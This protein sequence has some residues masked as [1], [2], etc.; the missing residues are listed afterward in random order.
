MS[1]SIDDIGD[2]MA[3]HERI[4]AFWNTHTPFDAAVSEPT[5]ET[6]S[7]TTDSEDDDTTPLAEGETVRVAHP[8]G[9][10]EVTRRDGEY[11]ARA[12]EEEWPLSEAAVAHHLETY[13]W[14][15]VDA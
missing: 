6:M 11:H 15:V 4:Q 12:G 1:D 7:Q 2:E 10:F 5:D 3:T 14:E 13:A 8:G 9:P